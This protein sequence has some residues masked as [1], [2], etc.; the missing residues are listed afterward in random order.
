MI[1]E[2]FITLLLFIC[3]ISIIGILNILFLV[4]DII[5]DMRKKYIA[6][7]KDDV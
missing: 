1:F 2:V 6:D 4:S 5:S 3:T 7:N